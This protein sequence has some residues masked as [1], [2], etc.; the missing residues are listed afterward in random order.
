MQISVQCGCN[1]RK[2]PERED[3]VLRIPTAERRR[4]LG[5]YRTLVWKEGT[6]GGEIAS[7]NP[8]QRVR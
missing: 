3:V 1:G 4:D 2:V 7:G 5:K 8:L 6:W